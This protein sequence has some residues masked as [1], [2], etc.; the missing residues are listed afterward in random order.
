MPSGIRAALWLIALTA[1]YNVVEGA[2]AI[3]S[4]VEAGSVTL[5]AF[6]A[7]S[8]LEVAAAGAV[9]WRLL[10]I[11]DAEGERRE[12][13]ALRVVGVTFLV[14]AA[15]VVFQA[16]LALRLGEGAEAS[17]VGIGL[18]VA[19]LISMPLIAVG[20]LKVA[21]EE[22]LPAL[23]AE[24]RETVACSYLSLTALIG[25]A[26]VWAFGWWWLD[27]IAALAMVPWLLREGVEGVRGDACFDGAM[28]CWCRS[29][30]YGVRDC[31]R[32]CCT[33]A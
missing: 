31:P 14:L 12:V 21:T 11:D 25:L 3:W 9:A 17:L 30:W 19:S 2:V 10:A 23:A 26:A 16:S 15:A 5:L 7:D 6:G 4:G 13:L 28:L 33:P 20:K 1:V 32:S 22:G 29:C 24:A 18:L 8:Y 27:A